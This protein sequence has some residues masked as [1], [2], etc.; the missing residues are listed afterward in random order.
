MSVFYTN[1]HKFRQ[2]EL[3]EVKQLKKKDVVV[4]CTS[5]DP[6]HHA[7]FV[8]AVVVTVNSA[9]C[10]VETNKGTVDFYSIYEL[11]DI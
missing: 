11:T 3:F 9:A 10:F 5:F 1:S 7:S 2:M 8:K 4:I 6:P